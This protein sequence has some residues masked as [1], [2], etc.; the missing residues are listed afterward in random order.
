VYHGWQYLREPAAWNFTDVMF[1]ITP[2]EI[3][4]GVVLGAERILTARS[5]RFGWPDGAAADVYVVDAEGK[6][7]PT[8][9]VREIIRNGRRLYEIR[10]P[11]DHFAI[12]VKRS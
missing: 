4:E 10:M 1:P 6:P 9:M 8:G 12:L 11:G 5:G 2:V 7:V 3:H